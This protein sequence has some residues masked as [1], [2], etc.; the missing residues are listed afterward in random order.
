MFSFGHMEVVPILVWSSMS[1]QGK[2]T[3]RMSQIRY[4]LLIHRLNEELSLSVSLRFTPFGMPR[5][6]RMSL[7]PNESI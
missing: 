1:S 2:S 4:I 5:G 3:P 7:V 6:A